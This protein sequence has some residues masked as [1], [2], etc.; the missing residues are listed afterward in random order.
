MPITI[1]PY[2]DP[3]KAYFSARIFKGFFPGQAPDF[4]GPKPMPSP[5]Q[6]PAPN[7]SASPSAPPTETE[8]SEDTEE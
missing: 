6:S 3:S 4:T 7:P 1:R 5:A 8:E 2:Q